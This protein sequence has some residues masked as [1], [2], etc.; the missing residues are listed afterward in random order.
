MNQE[1][2]KVTNEKNILD[3]EMLKEKYEA[4]SKDKEQR[5][6]SLQNLITKKNIEIFEL[7]K[8]NERVIEERDD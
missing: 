1:Q 3:Q 8:N 5:I 2:E 6:L 7:Q 4:E